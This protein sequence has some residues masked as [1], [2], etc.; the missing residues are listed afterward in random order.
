MLPGCIVKAYTPGPGFATVVIGMPSGQTWRV[1]TGA[2]LAA[3][4]AYLNDASARKPMGVPVVSVLAANLVPQNYTVHLVP[5]TVA[6]RAGATAALTLQLLADATIG[7]TIYRSRIEAA[8]VDTSGA[9]A[10]DL[11]APTVDFVGGTIDLATLG[12]VTFA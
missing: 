1:P 7:G 8:L 2:E 11:S 4:T 12:T 5:D 9:F 6:N 3:A 10:D